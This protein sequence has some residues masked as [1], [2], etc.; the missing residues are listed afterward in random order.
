MKTKNE[1]ILI[2]L[3]K[4]KHSEAMGLLP[5]Y[6]QTFVIFLGI[7]GVL[8]KYTFDIKSTYELKLVISLV[9]IGSCILLIFAATLGEMVRR[10]LKEDLNKLLD[11][12]NSPL[13]PENLAPLKFG[14]ISVILFA[15]VAFIGWI[16]ILF[17]I[18]C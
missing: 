7:N 9:G 3:F 6:I 1:T 16:Y 8:L 15:L 12:L 10:K 4:T 5:R 11:E 2:E 13:N 14:V 17:K 18:V